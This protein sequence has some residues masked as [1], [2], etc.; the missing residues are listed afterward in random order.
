MKI[1]PN[2]IFHARLLPTFKSALTA[3]KIDTEKQINKYTTRAYNAPVRIL[4][5]AEHEKLLKLT[6]LL[7]EFENIENTLKEI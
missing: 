6:N 1:A 2:T 5:Q 4:T 3:V 7:L